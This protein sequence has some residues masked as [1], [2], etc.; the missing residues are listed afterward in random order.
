MLFIESAEAVPEGASP[1]PDGVLAEGELTGHSHRVEDSQA[2][3]V[4]EW[5]GDM[6]ID[7]VG[8]RVAIVHQEHGTIL[9]PHGVYRVWRQRIRAAA[10]QVEPAGGAVSLAP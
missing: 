8:E 3:L 2:G 9:L 4:H 10:G 1:R 5:L 7:V 6:F